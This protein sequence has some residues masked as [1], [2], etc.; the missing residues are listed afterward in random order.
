[1]FHDLFW[2]M[3]QMQPWPKWPS[4]CSILTDK[5]NVFRE[6]IDSV[7]G[8]IQAET[9]VYRV[10]MA[11]ATWLAQ[12]ERRG[13]GASEKNPH[14]APIKCSLLKTEFAPCKEHLAD[15]SDSPSIPCDLLNCGKVLPHRSWRW[16][17]HFNDFEA[18]FVP[19]FLHFLQGVTIL[20]IFVELNSWT[21]TS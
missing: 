2:P 13:R 6:S 12:I 3:L 7:V 5:F 1:M 20:S 21:W 4:S 18:E 17:G 9:R 14:D 11:F 8:R 16:T 10:E 19:F 15:F